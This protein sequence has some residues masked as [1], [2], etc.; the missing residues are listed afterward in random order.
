M[1]LRIRIE[2]VLHWLEWDYGSGLKWYCIGC[3]LSG[4]E[5]YGAIT[6]SHHCPVTTPIQEYLE[7]CSQANIK[8]P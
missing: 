3:T 7:L 6:G 5:Y 2:M 4:R 1:G 8:E